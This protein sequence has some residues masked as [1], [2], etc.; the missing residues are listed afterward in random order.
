MLNAEV[1]RKLEGGMG[2]DREMMIATAMDDGRRAVFTSA[3]IIQ[4]SAL[5]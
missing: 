1:M 5:S 4:H 2:H 3:F